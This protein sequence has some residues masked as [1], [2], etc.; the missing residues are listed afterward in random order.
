M[1]TRA[2]LT[3]EQLPSNRRWI[4]PHGWASVVAVTPQLVVVTMSGYVDA[5]GG[6]VIASALDSDLR[7]AHGVG[8][9]LD[10]EALTRYD[11]EVRLEATK[12]LF[13]N[14]SRIDSMVALATSRL[15]RM[16]VAFS[17]AA[18]G[19]RLKSVDG[20]AEFEEAKRSAL[21]NASRGVHHAAF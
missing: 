13:R 21:Q 4:T 12:V 10:L 14:L 3:P 5:A 2:G 15:V 16:G 8:A 19:G 11:P 20:R 6:R 9:F 1:P 18:L 7:A 17:S